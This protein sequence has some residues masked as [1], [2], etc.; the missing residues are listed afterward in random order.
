MRVKE[1][2]GVKPGQKML[3][4]PLPEELL[5]QFKLRCLEQRTTMG[6]VVEHLVRAYLNGEVVL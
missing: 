1:K 5:H 6:S 3:Q 4:V 2:R